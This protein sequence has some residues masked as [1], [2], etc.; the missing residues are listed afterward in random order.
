MGYDQGK[1][2]FLLKYYI[3]FLNL[4]RIR[5][6]YIQFLYISLAHIYV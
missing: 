6:I 2:S 3:L 5:N 4:L 1:F